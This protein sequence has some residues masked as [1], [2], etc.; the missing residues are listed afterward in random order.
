MPY[1]IFFY[2][3]SSTCCKHFVI[4]FTFDI[5][6]LSTFSSMAQEEE[7]I[8]LENW[9]DVFLSNNLCKSTLYVSLAP[10]FFLCSV[11]LRDCFRKNWLQARFEKKSFITQEKINVEISTDVII[12]KGIIYLSILIRYSKSSEN[13]IA[14][15]KVK[16]KR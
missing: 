13:G 10:T 15:C 7:S 6:T 9:S 1:F 11:K 2:D 16:L 8:Y 3:F 14:S 4:F 12:Y 5:Y